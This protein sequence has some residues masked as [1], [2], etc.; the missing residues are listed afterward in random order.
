MP[1]RTPSVIPN[2][3]DLVRFLSSGLIFMARLRSVSVFLDNHCLAR[4]SKTVGVARKVGVPRGLKTRSPG[5]MMDVK[6]LESTGMLKFL[7]L[8]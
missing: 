3:P 6:G 8:E 2:A 4:V 1:L 7:L 5:G